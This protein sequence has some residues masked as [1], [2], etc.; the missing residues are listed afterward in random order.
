MGKAVICP[1]R[2]QVF[3]VYGDKLLVVQPAAV[4]K[5]LETDGQWTMAALDELVPPALVSPPA[6]GDFV[7][8][9]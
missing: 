9:L 6:L 8:G 7:E 1:A 3:Q 5:R 2:S 4:A